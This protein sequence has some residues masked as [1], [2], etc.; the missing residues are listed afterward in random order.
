MGSAVIAAD[1]VGRQPVTLRPTDSLYEA[2]QRFEAHGA[3]A[4]PVVGGS[5]LSTYLGVLSRAAVF[6]RVRGHM[7]AL[8]GG[9]RRE[10]AALVES[11]D[12]TQLLS[13]VSA[14]DTRSIERLPAAHDWVGRSLR[15]LDFRRR[16]GA[17]VLGVQTASRAVLHPP[18]PDRPLE[19]GDVLLVLRSEASSDGPAGT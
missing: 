7:D 18:D 14:V 9:F 17:E 19:A 13:A 15:D 11:A 12:V 10:H 4:L 2:M 8:Q 16:H 1:L 3:E 6:E 5:D